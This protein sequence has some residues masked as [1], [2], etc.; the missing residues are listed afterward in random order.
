MTELGAADLRRRYLLLAAV[1]V[2]AAALRLLPLGLDSFWLDETTTARASSL[3]FGDMLV[4]RARAGH[5]PLFF[6]LTWLLA[7]LPG[8]PE[9]CCACRRRWPGWVRWR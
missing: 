8:P 5:P 9:V 7:R 4:N 3:A 2:V 1:L 6:V